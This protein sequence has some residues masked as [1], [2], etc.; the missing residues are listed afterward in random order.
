MEEKAWFH[1]AANCS[2]A[3]RRALPVA[4]HLFAVACGQTGRKDQTRTGRFTV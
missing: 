2:H 4:C 1:N 3:P